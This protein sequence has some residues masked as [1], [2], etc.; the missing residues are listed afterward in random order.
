MKSRNIRFVLATSRKL[1]IKPGTLSL[2]VNHS[3]MAPMR[4]FTKKK[5]IPIPVVIHEK[6]IIPVKLIIDELGIYKFLLIFAAV[7][8]VLG[9]LVYLSMLLV[10]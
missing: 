9:L 6:V 7:I 2:A 3:N 4:K 8:G 10:F 1:P 5:S